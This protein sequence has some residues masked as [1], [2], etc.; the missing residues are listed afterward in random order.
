VTTRR[1]FLE[2]IACASAA[3]FL[4]RA[5]ISVPELARAAR[6]QQIL[7]IGAGL[8]GL[9]SATL[10]KQAGHRVT[11]VEARTRAGGRV[12]TAREAFADGLFAELGPAR[13]PESHAR[14]HAWADRFGV[15]F[16]PFSPANGDRLDVIEGKSVR[17]RPDS[18]PDFDAYPLP[19]TAEE[20]ATGSQKTIERWLAPFRKFSADF[21][22]PDWPPPGLAPYDAMTTR[23]YARHVGLSEGVDRWLALGFADKAG[24]PMSA[25]WV[26]RVL[27]LAAFDR[28][29]LRI[30]GGNDLLP[31]AFARELRSDIRYGTPVVA[32]TQNARGVTAVTESAGS[33]ARIEADR[34]IVTI[35][36]PVLR[37]MSF[38]PALSPEKQRAIREMRYEDLARVVLQLNA[39]PWEKTGLAGWAK[40]ELPSEIWHVTFD[41]PGPRALCGVYLKGEAVAQ[42]AKLP[43][44]ERLRQMAKH[45]D[46]VFPGVM[47]TVEGGISKVWSEDPWARGGHAALGPGQ[48]TAF[49]AAARAPE[50]RIHF[51]GEHTSAW[52]AWMEGAIESGERAAAEVHAA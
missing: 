7:V 48:V 39:R 13:I 45:V 31:A 26:Y 52:Q 12:L 24:I 40:S 22:S 10:L 41:R 23:E 38:T 30:R 9:V 29:L 33:R 51:A 18:P 19:F 15:T 47:E 43:E 42:L 5:A 35:P 37:D 27:S 6:P 3:G 50:G 32:L 46:S 17:Y 2:L 34:A 36:F 4:P 16:E 49:T 20:R 1:Q 11:I 28:P 21:A 25:L 8:A 14:I 44:A